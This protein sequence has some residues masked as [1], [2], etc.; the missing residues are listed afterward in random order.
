M[1]EVSVEVMLHEAS[2][3]WSNGHFFHH[4]KQFFGRSLAVSE[5]KRQDYLGTM[6]SSPVELDE[7]IHVDICTGC[8]HGVGRF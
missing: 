7:L 8:D 1:D 5:R 6:I 4:L 2:V 3:N